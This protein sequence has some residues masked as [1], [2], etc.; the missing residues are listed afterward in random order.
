MS[1]ETYEERVE[2]RRQ[3]ALD[4][5]ENDPVARQQRVIDAWWEEKLNAEADYRRLMSRLN[6]VGLKIW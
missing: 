5:F 2:P 1:D 6:E 3:A 4:A